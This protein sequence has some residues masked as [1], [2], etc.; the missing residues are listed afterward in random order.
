MLALSES[1]RRNERTTSCHPSPPPSTLV[2]R[3]SRRSDVLTRVKT[4]PTPYEKLISTN[5][6]A[7]VLTHL[8]LSLSLSLSLYVSLIS[9]LR[10]V[11]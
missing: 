7:V 5:R 11:Q 6:A 1:E 4:I 3:S 8:S 9:L 10:E 2:P